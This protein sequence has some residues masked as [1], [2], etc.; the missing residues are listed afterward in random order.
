MS[1]RQMC[2]Y[3]IRFGGR[4][5]EA[6]L[7]VGRMRLCKLWNADEDADSWHTGPRN[8][9]SKTTGS[10]IGTMPKERLEYCCRRNH[11]SPII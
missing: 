10:A 1:L 5:Q 2:S 11:H 3:C 9:A 8:E 4:V 6:R 7:M